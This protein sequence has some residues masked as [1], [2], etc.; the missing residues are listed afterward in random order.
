MWFALGVV[1]NYSYAEDAYTE[2]DMKAVTVRFCGEWTWASTHDGVYYVDPGKEQNVRLCVTNAGKKK[3]GFEYGFSESGI[4]NGR[5]CQGDI[6]TGN[7][8]SILIPWTKERKITIEP[9]SEQ[10]IEERIVIPA[11][12]SWLQLGCI[13]YNL[14]QP[15]NTMVG[16]MFS[17]KIRKVGYMDIMIWWEAAVKSSIKILNLSWGIFSTNKKVK[18]DV[19]DANNLKLT[20]LIGN[21]WNIS[22]NITITGRVTNALGFQQPFTAAVKA[23]APGSTNTFVVDAGILPSYKWFFTVSYNVQSDPQ[24]MFPVSDEKLKQPSYIADS[25]KI[26]IFSWIWVIVWVVLLLVLYKLFVPRR[27]KPATETATV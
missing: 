10:I 5:Y 11:G 1:A 17:L 4:W 25:W 21:E 8:F 16:G 27:A 14:L 7:K 3:V 2:A 24:F 18:A 23:V 20:F 15:E 12:M 6:G 9:M 22:Q 26:F 19:D 13:G